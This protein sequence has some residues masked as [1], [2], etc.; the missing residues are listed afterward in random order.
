MLISLNDPRKV[1]FKFRTHS[2][3]PSYMV[4]VCVCVFRNKAVPLDR[5]FTTD[6]IHAG[7]TRHT[8]DAGLTGHAGTF[9]MAGHSNLYGS[10]GRMVF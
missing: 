1:R 8:R 6:G 9:T 7:C 5:P 4:Y 3:P 2:L 10:K